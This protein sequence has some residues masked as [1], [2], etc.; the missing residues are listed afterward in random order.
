MPVTWS[1]I[2]NLFV[3]L[4]VTTTLWAQPKDNSPYSRLGLGDLV[5]QQFAGNLG[6]GGLSAAYTD[7]F[8]QNLLNPASLAFLRST[9]FEL[10]IFAEYASLNSGDQQTDVWSGNLTYLS[11]AFPLRNPINAELDRVKSPFNWG[12]AF[13]LQPYTN[14]DYEIQV[15]SETPELGQTLNNFNG[16]GGSYKFQW[17]HGVSYK[18]LALGANLGLL[19][20]ELASSR[21]VLFTENTQ[22]YFNDFKDDISVRAF[23]WNLGL[24][25][26]HE[27][28][29]MEEG[30]LVPNGKTLTI[31]AYGHTPTNLT[32]FSDKFY[33]SINPF[34]PSSAAD[35][36]LNLTEEKQAGQLPSEYTF[37][38]MY[39]NAEKLRIGAE[40]QIGNWSEYFAEAKDDQLTDTWA[41]AAGL[42]FIPDATSY[43]SY[44]KRI[45]Y[46][47]GF[48]YN[49]D[50]RSFNTDLTQYSITLG[51][52]LPITLVRSR[53]FVNF[54][55]EVGQFGAPEEINETFGKLT[56]GFTLNDN[57]WFFKRKF[58]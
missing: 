23:T 27:F 18:N 58:N 31:G 50:P 37:G 48:R 56:L 29:S 40:Y 19:F 25:Y 11:L 46:R 26:R 52:G 45:R 13:S 30:Q 8:H 1:S 4:F 47:L 9:S 36:I 5:T 53:A 42:E 41:V 21:E 16:T 24:L 51:L 33:R 39:E 43:N 28:K 7:P 34:Y 55:L 15:E 32:T 12:M 10:G 22:S 14:V 20:G 49:T 35:T 6:M 17:S 54:A 44:A 38:L 57:T 2:F 3:L